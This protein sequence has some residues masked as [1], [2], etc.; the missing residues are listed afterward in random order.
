[1]SINQLDCTI[2]AFFYLVAT[3]GNMRRRYYYFYKRKRNDE[4]VYLEHSS[5]PDAMTIVECVN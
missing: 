3:W 2:D 1:M 5:C 4:A